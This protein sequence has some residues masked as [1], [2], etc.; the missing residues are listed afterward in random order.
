MVVVF[1]VLKATRLK[2]RNGPPSCG[3]AT[4]HFRGE[5][6]YSKISEIAVA[7]GGLVLSRKEARNPRADIYG[8]KR[9]T[10]RALG[11]N[12]YIRSG[13]LEDFYANE[14]LDN[15]LF[16]CPGDVV[17]RL[18]SPMCPVLI[19]DGEEGL[20]VPSQLAVLKV[21]DNTIILPE[22]LR[23]Y[24]A[25]KDIQE[26]VQKIE[27]GTAQRTVKLGTIMDLPIVVPDIETQKK[28]VKID[29]LSRNRERIYLD[30]IEQERLLSESII[31][32]IIGGTMNDDE[33]RY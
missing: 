27:S 6:M 7:Q 18:F 32:K 30:L 9:L 14:P 17:I 1:V 16:T 21:K 25:Q 22:Y 13:E 8:Y 11:E 23:L 31:E 26:R 12:G 10:L 33:K 4:F 3:R 29:I 5:K 15:A 2:V 20:L 19:D 24:L 28:A